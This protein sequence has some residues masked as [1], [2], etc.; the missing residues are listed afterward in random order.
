MAESALLICNEADLGDGKRGIRF[1]LAG[2][3]AFVIQFR[4]KFF[5]YYNECRHVP[6]ELDWNEGD[7]F[8]L[9]GNYLVCAV[10]GATYLPENGLCIGGPCRGKQLKSIPLTRENGQLFAHVPEQTASPFS[11]TRT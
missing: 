8:D 4:G 1:E 7:F 6:V 3:K 2:K 11:T 5:A 10:H 9:S